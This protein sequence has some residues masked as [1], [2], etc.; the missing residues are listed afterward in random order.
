[1]NNKEKY[2]LHCLGCGREYSD[3][4]YR[5]YCEGDHGRSLLRSRYEKKQ[6]NISLD[7]PGMFKFSDWLPGTLKVH[8]IT[9]P[10]TYHSEKFAG[11]LGL[12]NLYISFNG[13]WPE[14]R[15]LMQSCSFKELEAVS[16]A[17]R[18]NNRGGGTL[19]VASAGNTARSF[20][21]VFSKHKIPVIIIVPDTAREDMW[22]T[23]EADGCVKLIT[24]A[25]E[26]DYSDCI[27]A[28][29]AICE[30]AGLI[31]EGGAFNVARRD[32]MGTVLLDAVRV[33]GELPHHYFQAVGSGTGALSIWEA[34]L[35]LTCDG[36]FGSNKIKLH[37][38]QNH[39]FCPI[40]YS[41]QNKS[42]ELVSIDDKKAKQQLG[43]VRAR[44][45]SNRKPPYSLPGGVYDAL[46]DT[47]GQVY[48]I[49]NDEL[50]EA[51]RLFEKLENI[52]IYEPAAVAV[53]SLV[54][55]VEQQIIDNDDIILLNITGGGLRRLKKDYPII[56][57]EPSFTA[58]KTG[59]A[60]V[61]IM[62]YLKKSSSVATDSSWLS[63]NNL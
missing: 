12:E 3:N 56:N 9:S 57:I 62:S 28:A 61:E 29:N 26:G 22:L 60:A 4:G 24:I 17:S 51:K 35:R 16:A 18:Y 59:S 25:G 47:G 37:L 43:E 33:I 6:I 10:A 38:S 30:S 53:A 48:S 40:Y 44:V 1:M 32:G 45:L 42:R 5:I 39:P 49:T 58:K 23:I 52:D 8:D 13:Y 11:Y 36:R 31:N 63:S 34:N 14:R 15:A 50:E 55:A 41:W 19:V 2:V 20:A 21:M 27:E 7:L 46:I 54:Q